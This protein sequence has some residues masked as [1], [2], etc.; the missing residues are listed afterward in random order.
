LGKVKVNI[1]GLKIWC[2]QLRPPISAI[3]T[4]ILPQHWSASGDAEGDAPGQY[5]HVYKPSEKA[6]T[7]WRF[8]CSG[9]RLHQDVSIFFRK[10]LSPTVALTQVNTMLKDLNLTELKSL[11]AQS[12]HSKISNLNS[13]EVIDWNGRR[14]LTCEY[15]AE[16]SEEAFCD[17]KNGPVLKAWALVYDNASE[18]GQTNEGGLSASPASIEFISEVHDYDTQI[19]AV[20]AAAESIKWK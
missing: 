13:A 3:K 18:G 17:F 10:I 14:V 19:S 1:K 9:L 15:L 11:L 16:P 4:L 12:T 6:K 7:A 2:Q 8:W 5:C 20:R